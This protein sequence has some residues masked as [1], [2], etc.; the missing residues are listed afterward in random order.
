MAKGKKKYYSVLQKMTYKGKFYSV[1][2]KILLTEEEKD[3]LITK[4]L[5]K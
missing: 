1:E 3:S 2:S 4:N 5:I